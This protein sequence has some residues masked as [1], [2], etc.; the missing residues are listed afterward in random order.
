MLGTTSNELLQTIYYL[1]TYQEI[2]G[3]IPGF[4]VGFCSYGESFIGIYTLDVYVFQCPLSL[5]N[6]VLSSEEVLYIL[7]TKDQ[8]RPPNCV[9]V[10]IWVYK[11][12]NPL[13][14]YK[15]TLKKEEE[16]QKWP[17]NSKYGHVFQ[18]FSV[19]MSCVK[20]ACRPFLDRHA[21]Q[22]TFNN[23]QQPRLMT[24]L[25]FPDQEPHKTYNADCT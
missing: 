16:S 12:K 23:F 21:D 22:M 7:L 24:S 4:A 2:P 8:R 10:L 6:P 19:Y 20:L 11:R 3:L 5:F 17:V 18:H 15:G 9:R 14:W 25:T 13:K 1:P